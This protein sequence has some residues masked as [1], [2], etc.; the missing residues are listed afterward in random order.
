[1]NTSLFSQSR[2]VL[3]AKGASVVVKDY[4]SREAAFEAARKRSDIRDVVAS[5]LAREFTPK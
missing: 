5:H 3:D 4:G 2:R 1:M